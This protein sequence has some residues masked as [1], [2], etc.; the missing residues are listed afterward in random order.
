MKPF[1]C[2]LVVATHAAAGAALP[3]E[4]RS[5]EWLK[6]TAKGREML[7]KL[8][9][10]T[11]LARQH[12]ARLQDALELVGRT[13][14][15]DWKKQ[16]ALDLLENLLADL[17]AGVEPTKR[18]AGKQ[19]GFP[20]WSERLRRVEAIWLHVPPAYEPSKSYQLFVYY[21]CGGGIHL[22][23]GKAAGGYRPT[24]EVANQTDTFHAWSSLNIQIK[25]RMGGDYEL[26]EALPALA[27]F[28]SVDLDRVFLTGWSDGGFTAL[29]IASRFPDLVA[30]IAPTC[31]NWQYSNVCDV[32]LCNVPLLAVDGWSDGGYNSLQF[33]RWHT[34]RT[35]G[36]DAAGLWGHH[37]HA[38][39]P[40]E[41]VEEFTRILDWAKS[42]RRNPWPKRVRYATWN[43]TW[44]RSFWL[45]I[46]RTVEPCLAA[47][48][49]AEARDGN[50]IEVKASNVAA[51]TLSLGD[52][53]VDPAKPVT[54]V[55]NGQPCYA[56]PFRDELAVE[57]AP[58]PGKLVKCAD[59]P[60][61]ITAQINRSCYGPKNFLK[62]AGRE[63]LWVKPTGGD[64]KLLGKWTGEWAKAD[65]E[66]TEADLARYNLLVY[67]GPD[68]NRLAA[69]IAA[70]LPVKFGQGRFTIGSRVYDLPSHCVKLIH[71]NPLHPTKYVI[72]YAF[73]DAATFAAHDYFGT[74]EESSWKLRSGDCVVM[75]IPGHKRAW[76]VEAREAEFDSRHIIFDAAWRA[77][78]ETPLGQLAQPFG[79][80]QL[81]RLRA[82]AIREAAG[83]D[84]G[85]IADHT[86]GWNHWRSSLPAGPV[87][88]HDIATVDMLPEFVVLCDVAGSALTGLLK[89]AAATTVLAE[90]DSAKTY[91]VAMGHYGRPAYGAEPSKMPKLHYF[92]T[93]EQFLAGGHTSFPVRNM[94]AVPMDVTEAVAAYI[95]KR[96]KVAPRPTC[97]SLADYV[98]NPQTEE[99]GAL[100]WL[101]LGAN[102]AWKAS[103]SAGGA[104]QRSRYTLNIGL[105]AASDPELAP[106]RPN[107][108]TF[109]ELDLG[110]ATNA[111]FAG[112]GKK[113][114]V[115]VVAAARPFAIAAD[116][117]GTSFRLAAQGAKDIVATGILV[118]LCLTNKGATGV[119]GVA[120]LAP[121][122]M[123]RIEGGT[124]PDKSL[125]QPLATSYV[126]YYQALGEGRGK[127]PV[128]QD[129]ALLLFG[130]AGRK[131]EPLVAPSAGY[132]FGLVGISCPIVVEA[133]Q[134]LSVPLLFVAADTPDKAPA[135][136]LA[137]ALDAVRDA[138]L[139]KLSH[140][141]SALQ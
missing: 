36:A 64:P 66:V 95:R 23:D 86:P 127:P 116:E 121:S 52:K 9:P 80:T 62:V 65:T 13:E 7:A 84:V 104:P 132:N 19:L 21:K 81:L 29:W 4:G 46:Q 123:R 10:S 11:P 88:L 24:A 85:L 35:M 70:G 50:R 34:L 106:P 73:N 134:S 99:F 93:P 67:G 59:M 2:L 37:G 25:G 45:A 94:H 58:A 8:D 14:S 44:H 3:T 69:R 12:A 57:L 112:M 90:P 49:D 75:G 54:V 68:V 30:G 119:A 33:A 138:L 98:Q 6:A 32:G 42:K 15:F 137:A 40:F 43:L 130:R 26:R 63:W 56:G 39:Q 141:R 105:R 129:A 74:R 77:P 17:L 97:F 83:A 114:P 79:Y 20:Y 102:V 136:N 71:P 82:D 101:H 140:P 51:Y 107:S 22:K 72:L 61:G 27:R 28:F 113:L 53:L 16:T 31:A 91:R 117:G 96:G 100:D 18:Y 55:T 92:E 120:V 41:D 87:T 38:Y 103:S 126:G 60:D 133:G 122:A 125:R 108:K 135:P 89:D 109:L 124:W 48:I 47:W 139:A 131:V 76:G 1:L 110:G 5:D 111:D 115:A 118:D 128:H 78:D